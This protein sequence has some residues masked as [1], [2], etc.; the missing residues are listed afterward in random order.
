M[1]LSNK[2]PIFSVD[3]LTDSMNSEKGII[4]KLN[5][6]NTKTLKEFFLQFYPSVCVFTKK[7]ISESD[8]VEDIAQEAFLVYWESQKQFDELSDLKGFL[9]KTAKYKCMNYLKLK[10]LREDILKNVYSDKEALYEL[11]LE[12][13]T[14]RII[15]KAIENLPVQSQRIIQLSM[16]GYKNP[17][18]AE[19]MGVSINTIKTLKGN[20]YKVLRRNL[21]EC[22]YVLLLLHQILGN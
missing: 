4:D 15:H 22:V 10:S 2:M 19:E 8:V 16:K 12:E 17:E 6:R 1:K 5:K 11:I 9:Y 7:F 18:I 13:E 20:A 3:D 21:K 14:Y